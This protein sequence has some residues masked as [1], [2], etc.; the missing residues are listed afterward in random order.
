MLH[1]EAARTQRSLSTPAWLLEDARQLF[2]S[3]CRYG[4]NVD[5]SSGIV[6]T[7]DED[8]RPVVRERLHWTLAEASAAAA[9]LWQRTGEAQYQTWYTQFWD[10]IDLHLIDRQHGSWHH[11]LNP[12]NQPSARIWPG[13]PDLYHAYQATLLPRLP[14]AFSLASALEQQARGQNPQTD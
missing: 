5:G 2:H 4:W 1:L 3:A 6:Y 12:A 11:E 7:L 14:L 10:Y 8:N 9:A 13:K